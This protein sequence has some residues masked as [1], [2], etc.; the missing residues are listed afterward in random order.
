MR[1]RKSDFFIKNLYKKIESHVD[2]IWRSHTPTLSVNPWFVA[3]NSC[4]AEMPRVTIIRALNPLR[5][6]H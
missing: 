5:G 4:T 6:S 3:Y 2:I 1:K